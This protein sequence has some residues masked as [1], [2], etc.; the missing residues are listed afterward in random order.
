MQLCVYP[1]A[2]LSKKSQ[3]V[4][5]FDAQL[6]QLIIDLFQNLQFQGGVGLSACQIGIDK[7]IFVYKTPECQGVMINPKVIDLSQETDEAE[8]GCLSLPGVFLRIKRPLSVTM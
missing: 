8:E 1:D 6:S 4:T 3:L 7:A 5:I 2:L